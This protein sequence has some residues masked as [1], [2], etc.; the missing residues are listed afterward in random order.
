MTDST[1]L[2]K[3]V[4]SDVFG[5]SDSFS[6]RLFDPFANSALVESIGALDVDGNNV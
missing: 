2:I 6:A 1:K 4:G 3:S 5:P